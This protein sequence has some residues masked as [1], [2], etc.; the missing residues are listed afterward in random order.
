MTKYLRII[1]AASGERIIEAWVKE[2]QPLLPIAEKE[3]KEPPAPS[4]F[5]FLSFVGWGMLGI[6]IGNLIFNQNLG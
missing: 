1:E 4:S 5:L 3:E 2:E 6:Y